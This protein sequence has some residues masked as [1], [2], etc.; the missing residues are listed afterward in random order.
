MEKKKLNKKLQL[1]KETIAQLDNMDKIRGGAI[2]V[3][4]AAAAVGEASFHT[5]TFPITIT[6]GVSIA[7]CTRGNCDIKTI[8][9]D[10]GTIC[11]SKKADWCHGRPI[12]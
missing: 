12:N 10:D 3:G 9:H 8:G 4:D 2:F 1:N 11:L 7:V 5:L 6:I